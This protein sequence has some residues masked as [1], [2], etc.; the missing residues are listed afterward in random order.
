MPA[1]TEGRCQRSVSEQRLVR[2]KPGEEKMFGE[3]NEK[4]KRFGEA[5]KKKTSEKPNEK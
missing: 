4:E 2:R 1:E 3:P 5:N